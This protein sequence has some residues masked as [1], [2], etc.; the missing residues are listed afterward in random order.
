LETTVTAG[1]KN[2]RRAGL[3]WGEINKTLRNAGS[4]G[5]ID[6]PLAHLRMTDAHNRNH[7]K[8]T[9]DDQV[10]FQRNSFG[11]MGNSGGP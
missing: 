11:S 10:W 9:A 2:Y 7:Q 3:L 5:N 8:Y 4:G 6:N 1:K